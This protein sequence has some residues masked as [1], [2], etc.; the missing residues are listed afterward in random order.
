PAED[1]FSIGIL[2]AESNRGAAQLTSSTS[3][4]DRH[5][6]F[7]NDIDWF[8][9][10]LLDIPRAN[11]PLYYDVSAFSE[12]LRVTSTSDG[13]LQWL[14]GVF[15]LDRDE[16]SGQSINPI[17][18]PAPSNPD[19]NVFYSRTPATTRQLAGFFELG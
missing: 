17:G 8:T 1:D 18:V 14:M 4:F 11:S 3:Y 10:L 6:A 9:E 7:G 19:A 16:D 12:E 15:Y 5:R 13:P 2:R